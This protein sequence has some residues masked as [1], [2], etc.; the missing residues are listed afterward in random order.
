[1]L[2][3][4]TILSSDSDPLH[5]ALNILKIIGVALGILV[6]V[7]F[8]LAFICAFINQLFQ[9]DASI[10]PTTPDNNGGYYGG[11]GGYF[12]SGQGGGGGGGG[13]SYVESSATRVHSSQGWKN[14][15]TG[16]LVVFS[17]N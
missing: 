11:G 8:F 1:M 5:V 17:W 14:A 4:L 16:G 3:I 7:T 13:S 12:S 2:L 9:P 6:G 15:A 10:V